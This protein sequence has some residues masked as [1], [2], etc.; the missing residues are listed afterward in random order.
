MKSSAAPQ[1]PSAR[2]SL[3]RRL[4]PPLLAALALAWGWSEALRLRWLC[5]DAFISFRYAENLVAGLGLVFNAGE[6]VEGYTN[7]LWTLALAGAA[8][9]GLSAPSTALAL[10]LLC[11]A[12]LLACVWRLGRAMAGELQPAETTGA[13]TFDWSY[14]PAAAVLLALHRH[15]QVF[16]TSGLETMA[17]ALAIVG[18][19]LLV[20]RARPERGPSQILLT[21]GFLVF[22][23]A[24]MLRP[25]GLLFYASG[26]LFAF[27]RRRATGWRGLLRQAAAHAPFALLYVPY[28]LWRY[29][30]YGYIFP[31][32]YYAKS[33][34]GV[35]WEQGL[36]YF[37]LYFE[38]Y[39]VFWIAPITLLILAL[40]YVRLESSGTRGAKSFG[41]AAGANTRASGYDAGRN[42]AIDLALLLLLPAALSIF[43]YTRVGGDFMF[44]RFL[45]P[46]TPLLALALEG[47]G[48]ILLRESVAPTD[49]RGT[50]QASLLRGGFF[51]LLAILTLARSDPYRGAALPIIAGVAE[52]YRIY[53]PADVERLRSIARQWREPF[54][55]GEIRL[56]V[57]GSQVLLGYAAQAPYLLEAVTGLTDEGLAHREL[58]AND[59]ATRRAG[60]VGHEKSAGLADLRARRIHLSLHTGALP[61][62]PE[63]ARVEIE[64]LPGVQRIVCYEIDAMRALERTPG[65]RMTRFEN[66]LDKYITER[67]PVLPP[68]RI[69]DDYREFAAYYFQWN[70]DAPRENA[71]RRALGLP[72]R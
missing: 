41:A 72:P 23:L 59:G 34:G 35:Y 26:A 3:F 50:S 57:W 49:R 1:P 51:T 67:L 58:P 15:M 68:E 44:A 24:A 47:Y 33:G 6:R 11:Y 36:R 27:L 48:R 22:A 29:N 60:M 63:Y 37:T 30:Y 21:A 14:F 25:D 19:S 20:F 7:F 52:E 45:I 43:Y 70:D 18:G 4:T 65:L 31:N 13:N 46:A 28:W 32:T 69:R 9:L 64:G 16:A 17:F 39:Y 66:W 61:P 2:A 38:S 5:D 40:L 53:R 54:V 10:G 8:S 42:L 12:G 62:P 71:F 56:A 55:E